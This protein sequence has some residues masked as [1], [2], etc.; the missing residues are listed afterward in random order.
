LNPIINIHSIFHYY[1]VIIIDRA[2]R[3]FFKDFRLAVIKGKLKRDAFHVEK[4]C[5]N[6][7]E[8]NNK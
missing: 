3:V 7:T 2:S 6:P 5:V 8:S 4:M 1:I